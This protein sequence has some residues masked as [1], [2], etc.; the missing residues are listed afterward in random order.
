MKNQLRCFR[1]KGMA[2]SRVS[3]VSSVSS[4]SDKDDIRGSQVLS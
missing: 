3:S 1:H 2:C 4:F